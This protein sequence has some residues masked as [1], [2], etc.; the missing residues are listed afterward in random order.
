M[1][2]DLTDTRTRYLGVRGVRLFRLRVQGH[3]AVLA[4]SSRP[5]LSYF[6]Q[7]RRPI[8]PFLLSLFIMH[9]PW[10]HFDLCGPCMAY[11][12]VLSPYSAWSVAWR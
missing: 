12:I 8:S 4:L 6:H 3:A 9:A 1:Q 10:F 2:G 11:A 5:W 7:V